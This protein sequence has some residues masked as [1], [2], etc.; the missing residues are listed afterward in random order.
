[1][2]I[3]DAPQ[4][5]IYTDEEGL[6]QLDGNVLSQLS[7]VN[8]KINV[9]GVCGLYRTGKSYLMNWIAGE[10]TGKSPLPVHTCHALSFK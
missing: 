3:F 7:Q 8:M 2:T 4:R 6:L 10:K 1:L 5:L 9:V